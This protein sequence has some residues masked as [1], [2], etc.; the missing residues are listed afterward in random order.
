[1]FGEMFQGNPLFDGAALIRESRYRKYSPGALQNMHDF[2]VFKHLRLTHHLGDLKFC[3]EDEDDLYYMFRS[4]ERV[5]HIENN[6][7]VTRDKAEELGTEIKR[8]KMRKL[9]R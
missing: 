4:A 5:G 7:T 1:M 9:L 3:L 2:A 6:I 8:R